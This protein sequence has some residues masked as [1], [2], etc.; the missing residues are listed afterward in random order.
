MALRGY[1]YGDA[2]P[3]MSSA[4]AKANANRVEYSRG[5][6]TEWYLNGPMGVEQGFTV[7]KA[8]GQANGQPLTVALALSGDFVARLERGG[9]GLQLTRPNRP[10]LRY[11]GLVTFGGL[12]PIRMVA[13]YGTFLWR[14][15]A[16]TP[17][18]PQAFLKSIGRTPVLMDDMILLLSRLETIWFPPIT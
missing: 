16:A 4:A 7:A 6:L 13:P 11:G 10:A 12:L 9:T 2:L 8:P 15:N 3:S 17:T 5:T 14:C 1:G 18:L